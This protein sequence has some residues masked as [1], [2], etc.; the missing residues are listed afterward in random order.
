MTPSEP[1]FGKIDDKLLEAPYYLPVLVRH[2]KMH[3][4]YLNRNANHKE[5]R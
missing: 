2:Q 4:R 5:I 1:P 3:F